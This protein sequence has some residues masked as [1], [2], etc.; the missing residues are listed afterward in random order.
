MEV[1]EGVTPPRGTQKRNPRIVSPFL[2]VCVREQN[3]GD[4]S[5]PLCADRTII[6]LDTH[7]GIGPNA[8]RQKAS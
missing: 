8:K 2:R 7:L 1:S 4:R 3:N 5:N 6:H